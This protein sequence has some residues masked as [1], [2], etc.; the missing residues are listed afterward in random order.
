MWSLVDGLMTLVGTLLLLFG[1]MFLAITIVAVLTGDGC[2][3]ATVTW[4]DHEYS[5]SE[6]NGAVVTT[7]VGVVACLVSCVILL[8]RSRVYPRQKG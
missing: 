3:S 8:L 7:A 6:G 2:W 1:L 5:A 4:N